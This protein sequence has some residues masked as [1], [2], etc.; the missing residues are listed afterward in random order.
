[1]TP[2][3]RGDPAHAGRFGNRDNRGIDES[4][5]QSR[6][7]PIE[8]GDARM[9]APGQVDDRVVISPPIVWRGWADRLARMGRIVRR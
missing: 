6:V 2:V 8:I 3:G 1:M 5:L 9:A 7:L 4:E